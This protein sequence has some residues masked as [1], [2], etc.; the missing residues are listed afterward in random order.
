MV[1]PVAL[2]RSVPPAITA[3]RIADVNRLMA[4]YSR[5]TVPAIGSI[6]ADVSTQDPKAREEAVKKAEEAMR[7]AE[8]HLRRLH[9]N[10]EWQRVMERA[11]SAAREGQNQEQVRKAL[12]EARQA[13]RNMPK[14]DEWRKA[15]E[16]A[17]EAMRKA[18]ES[19]K[20][21]SGGVE[22]EMT[23]KEKE[24]L[25]KALEKMQGFK[26][27]DLEFEKMMKDFPSKSFMGPEFKLDKKMLDADRLRFEEM[28]KVIPKID[29]KVFSAPH[30]QLDKKLL[31]E[32]MRKLEK[33]MKDLPKIDSR[34]FLTPK[35]DELE[36]GRAFNFDARRIR[37]TELLKS[38]TAEQRAKHDKQGYLLFSDLTPAQ[39]EML[40]NTPREGDWTFTYSVDGKKLTVRNK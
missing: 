4:P 35:L 11:M 2:N 32:Q 14:S 38:I 23:A 3:P 12:E 5:L 34:A 10:G 20:V 28:M 8:Q 16:T 36:R 24:A 9:E 15:W 19:G 25:Q 30:F 40:G 29:A 1:P 33:E 39:R 7:M 31:E 37:V 26:A 21:R 13:L 18:I 22:R 6:R 17:R 27:P